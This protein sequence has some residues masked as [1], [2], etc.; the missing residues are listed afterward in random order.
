MIKYISLTLFLLGFFETS[1][2][3]EKIDSLQFLLIETSLD[4]LKIDVYRE[5]SEAYKHVNTDTSFQYAELSYDLAKKYNYTKREAL[6]LILM[7]FLH[8]EQGN[9][10]AAKEN[11]TQSLDVSKALK[12]TSLMAR[13]SNG[14]GLVHWRLSE[15]IE[16]LHNF[17]RAYDW[18]QISKNSH[19]Y[20]SAVGNIGLINC[21][22]G[23]LEEGIKY[24]EQSVALFQENNNKHGEAIS[25]MNIAWSYQRMEKYDLALELYQ[26]TID[27]IT[28]DENP[29]LI[30]QIYVNITILLGAQDKSDEALL[31]SDKAIAICNKFGFSDMMLS[32]LGVKTE[33]LTGVGRNMEAVAIAKEGIEQAKLVGLENLLPDFYEE[34]AKAYKAEGNANEAFDWLQKYASMK[35]S[36]FEKNSQKEIAQLEI[37][38]QSKQKDIENDLLKKEKESQGLVIQQR[39]RIAMGV[40]LTM[41]LLGII[42]F[43]LYIA[44]R[45]TK[46]MNSKLEDKVM[47]RTKEL[48]EMN[49]RLLLSN[50]ELQRF[51]FI[52]SHDLKEPL[53]NIGGFITLIKR[54][55]EQKHYE[56]LD[57][58]IQFVEKS[59]LQMVE[60]VE[61]ILEYSKVDFMSTE[62]NQYT[63]VQKEILKV[64][65]LLAESFSRRNVQ[66]FVD[67]IPNVQCNPSVIKTVLKN[68]IENALKYNKSESPVIRISSNN[69][70]GRFNLIV[71]DNG[72]GIAPKHHQKVFDMFVRLNKREE[73]SG[74]GMGLAFCKK[75]LMNNGGSISIESEEGKG[76]KFKV[77]LPI[78]ED[79]TPLPKQ[80]DL[81]RQ[82]Q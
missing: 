4:T 77:T 2:Q 62:T 61:T 19:I 58:Y 51:A 36:L 42:A 69:E 54:R 60:L 82:L 26:K 64:C 23:R 71:S 63:D 40:G 56:S 72:I 70:G 52:A 44:R 80:L 7:G 57:E 15:D 65:E 18:A 34:I 67:D 68:L 47:S 45:K 79:G 20:T 27:M 3:Y 73:Y 46:R 78:F 49:K 6:A 29:L 43:Q 76:S 75:I 12:D 31:F 35:D 39:T 53:R 30:A 25:T 74:S 81:D 37:S 10:V 50:D 11:F 28:V 5:L 8:Y 32:A 48:E 55:I 59:N 22:L 1:A 41:V 16:A 13:V 9:H 17:Q 14:L 38:F 66:L 33:A 21:D 24:F